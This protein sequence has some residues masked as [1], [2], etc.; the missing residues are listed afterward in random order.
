MNSSMLKTTT[1]IDATRDPEYRF[2]LLEP[3]LSYGIAF[4][5][6]LFIVGF[7]WKIGKV[8]IAGLLTTALS[9]MAFMP[10]MSARRES[11]PRIEQIFRFNVSGRGKI[12]TENTVLW[13]AST[14][15]YAGVVILATATVVVG[16]RRNQLGYGLSAATVILGLMAIQNSLWMH[17]QDASAV[18]P[19]LKA[20]RAP[21]EA[22]T[23]IH[24]KSSNRLPEQNPPRESIYSAPGNQGNSRQR[25]VRP[26]N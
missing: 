3:I 8:Q 25:Y 6:I 21:I 2:L 23:N 1:L 9:A 12:F 22:V 11:L 15:M 20:H 7:I 19:N 4:G 17:Y 10:Y 5:I 26:I 18:H 24:T 14:W 13:S 16:A